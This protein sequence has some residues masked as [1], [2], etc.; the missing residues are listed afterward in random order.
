MKLSLLQKSLLGAA[1]ATLLLPALSFGRTGLAG[2]AF[3]GGGGGVDPF[4]PQFGGP[5]AVSSGGNITSLPLVVKISGA[6]SAYTT[7]IT[8][9]GAG[10][11][12]SGITNS[13][14]VVVLS[15]PALPGLELDILGTT[16]VGVPVHGGQVVSIVID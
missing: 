11:V 16:V 3:S 10:V 9:P 2:G 1:V 15:V 14:G 8:T 5:K 12:A 7:V 4:P 6:A 13:S